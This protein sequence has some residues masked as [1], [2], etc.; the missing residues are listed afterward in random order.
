MKLSHANKALV[1]AFIALVAVVV[2]GLLTGA[3]DEAGLTTAIN[4]VVAAFIAGG[5]VFATVNKPSE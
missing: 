4:S 3:M 1:A 5:A 2:Q